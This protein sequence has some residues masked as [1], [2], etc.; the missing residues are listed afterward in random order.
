[1]EGIFRDEIEVRQIDKFFCDEM[2]RQVHRYIKAMHGSLA[3]LEKFEA[4]LRQLTIPEREEVLA[5][6]IDLN[7]KVVK[8]LDWRMLVARA[9]A[10]F[11]D[12]YS[13]FSEVMHDENTMAF[14]VPRMKEKYIRLHEVFEENGKYGIKDHEGRVLLSASYDFLRTPY[15]YVDDLLTMPVIAEKSGKMGLV[16]P[17]YEDTVVMPFE[18]D[19][20]SLRDEEPWFEL[21]RNGVVTYWPG[22][23]K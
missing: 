1:M 20:I 7:R 4:R 18:Y 8:D 14:Y 10:N 5:R 3:M 21:T 16:F 6:Y 11:C 9:M 17:D 2:G 19:D 12:S 13:Y 15:V 23:P 22:E